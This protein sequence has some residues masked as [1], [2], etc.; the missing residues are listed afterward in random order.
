MDDYTG[1]K[2]KEDTSDLRDI[3]V[4]RDSP[5]AGTRDAFLEL[6]NK[7]CDQL[8]RQWDPEVNITDKSRIR[9]FVHDQLDG[10]LEQRGIILNRS[11]KRQLLEAIVTDLANSRS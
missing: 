11:E 3:R 4:R 1:N 5:V 7:L 6:K 9:P 10:L 8:L 2:R